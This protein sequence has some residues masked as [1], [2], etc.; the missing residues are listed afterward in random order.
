MHVIL[1]PFSGSVFPSEERSLTSNDPSGSKRPTKPNKELATESPLSLPPDL[2]T[3]AA[4]DEEQDSAQQMRDPESKNSDPAHQKQNSSKP[5]AGNQEHLPRFTLPG[6]QFVRQLGRGGMGTVYLATDETLGREVA[7]KVVSQAALRSRGLIDRFNAEVKT[8]AT[9]HHSNI[10]QLFSAGQHDQHPYFVMEY[11]EGATL[12]ESISEPLGDREAATL[13][14]TLCDAMGYCHQQ[15]IIHRDLKPSNILLTKDGQPKIAD[16]GLAKAL[17]AETSS[18]RTGDVLGTPGYMSPEQASGVIKNIGPACD[19]Y[20]LGAV[21]YKLLTGRPPF[22]AAEPVQTIVQVLSDDPVKPRQLNPSVSR[23]LETVCLKCLEKKPSNR[24]PVVDEFKEDLN[25]FLQGLPINAKPGGSIQRSLKWARRNPAAT[26]AMASALLGIIGTVIA[27]TFHNSVL[28]KELARSRRLADHG[29]EFAKWITNEHLPELSSIG[30]TTAPRVELVE[31]VSRFLQESYQDMPADIKYTERLGYT[32]SQLAANLGG[33]SHNTAGDLQNAERFYQRA[34]ELYDASM[35]G[36]DHQS[37]VIRLKA[38]ALIALADIYEKLQD[39]ESRSTSLASAQE[40][41]TTLAVDDP[42]NIF[43]K[44]Q[45]LN[46][47][48]DSLMRA[49]KFEETLVVLDGLERSIA[50][51]EAFDDPTFQAEISNQEILVAGHRG[52]CH[53]NLGDLAKAE[54]RFREMV[55]LAKSSSDQA[56]DNVKD[57]RRTAS[58]L[59]YLG[60]ILFSQRK[61]DEALAHFEQALKIS[62]KLAMLDPASVEAKIDLGVKLSRIATSCQYLAKFQQGL[63]A[64]TEAIEILEKLK[65]AGQQNTAIGRGLMVYWQVAGNLRFLL[66]ENGQAESCFQEHGRLCQSRLAVDSQDTFTL[67]Q[68]GESHLNRALM[69]FGTWTGTEVESAKTRNDP[70]YQQIKDHLIDGQSWYAKIE[71]IMPLNYHQEQQLKRLKDTE[72]ML[73][74]FIAA[75]EAIMQQEQQ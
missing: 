64:I 75:A 29:S 61:A 53:E 63:T 22:A 69:I 49:H 26:I 19:V 73:E 30:G 51:L 36:A 60:D 55:K 16:F 59:V 68:L 21:L 7:I 15:N 67:N 52:Y 14:S 47:E 50:E 44:I 70:E 41:V 48:V 11:V 71:K 54:T 27:L 39:W 40:L 12:E 10:A 42:P 25:N 1:K 23:E 35:E 9:L 57:L 6:F 32:Y 33:S 45:L 18:T 66:G 72:S 24:Y 2:E 8:L 38:D 74:Q 62:R 17:D 46:R 37:R 3:F 56:P 31:K 20:G 65:S 28:A 13:V 34:I 43:L 5:E 58:T 4:G